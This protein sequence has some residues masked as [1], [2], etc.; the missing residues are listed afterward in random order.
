MQS[1]RFTFAPVILLS[2]PSGGQWVNKTFYV[3]PPS[4][5]VV[6]VIIILSITVMGGHTFSIEFFLSSTLTCID[7]CSQI[8]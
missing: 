8:K 6:H 1:W 5:G 4:Q 3:F 2:A 7:M